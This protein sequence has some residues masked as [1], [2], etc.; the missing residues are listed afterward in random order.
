MGQGH[1]LAIALR[2]AYWSMHRRTEECFRLDGVTAEQFVVLSIL[3]K[4]APMTQT[5]LAERA[6]TDSNTLRAILKLLENRELVSRNAHPSDGRAWSI[7]I[8][9]KGRTL[10][11][12][13]WKTSEP[14]RQ[15]W[16]DQITP[17]S[18]DSLLDLLQQFSQCNESESSQLLLRN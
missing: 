14:L 10:Y 5:Q 13:L 11:R 7:A 4:T 16:L 6:C 12:K 8:T 1:E 9:R 3:S 17:A 2:R 15:F 18:V